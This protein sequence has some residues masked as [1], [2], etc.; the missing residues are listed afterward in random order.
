VNVLQTVQ[1][2]LQLGVEYLKL[3]NKCFLFDILDKFDARIDKL[4]TKRDAVRNIPTPVAQNVAEKINEEIIE[5]QQKMYLFLQ[6][7]K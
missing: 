1:L 3:R 4:T 6:D 2:L 7:R 5:E